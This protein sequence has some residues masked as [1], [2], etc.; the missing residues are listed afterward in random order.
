M[1]LCV[2]QNGDRQ[3]EET[4]GDEVQNINTLTV[5]ANDSYEEFV[6]GLQSEISEVLYNRPEKASFQYF[7]GKTVV[8]DDGKKQVVTDD[9]A[10]QIMFW[11]AM[12]QYIDQ[13]GKIKDDYREDLK[14]GSIK[15]L[16]PA[17]EP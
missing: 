3:D 5:I 15:P 14:N 4:L 7:R 9:M 2:D 8:S 17:L 13:D 1:R 16:P 12:N 6:K 10:D 11:L